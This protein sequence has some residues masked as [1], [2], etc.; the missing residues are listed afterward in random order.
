MS[1]TLHQAPISGTM[2]RVET[3]GLVGSADPVGASNPP[4]T[5]ALLLFGI[6]LSLLFA[7]WSWQDRPK[8]SGHGLR[9][10]FWNRDRAARNWMFEFSSCVALAVVLVGW[11][12]SLVSM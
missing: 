12:V 6:A 4:L 5:A 10:W 9:W 2:R 8:L 11:L 7:R 1:E 3:S